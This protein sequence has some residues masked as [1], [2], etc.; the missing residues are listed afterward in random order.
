[1]LN[2]KGHTVLDVAGL[3]LATFLILWGYDIRVPLLS[4][5]GIG[6]GWTAFVHVVKSNSNR[7]R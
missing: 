6:V 7:R 2:S 5:L 1:M 3:C 4:A